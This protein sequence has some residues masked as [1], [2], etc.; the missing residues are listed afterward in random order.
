MVSNGQFLYQS[1]VAKAKLSFKDGSPLYVI[2]QRIDVL[3]CS[4]CLNSAGLNWYGHYFHFPFEQDSLNRPKE[5]A[6]GI[7]IENSQTTTLRRHLQI[8]SKAPSTSTSQT[9]E[10]YELKLCLAFATSNLSFRLIDKPTFRTI[11][12]HNVCH[13]TKFSDKILS[14]LSNIFQN[15]LKYNVSHR[16]IHLAFDLW[17]S[18]N[19][20]HYL[21]LCCYWFSDWQMNRAALDIFPMTEQ[22]GDAIVAAV[23]NVLT[24]YGI[25]EQMIASVCTD[26]ASNEVAAATF[27][28]FSVNAEHV[29]YEFHNIFS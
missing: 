15:A 29:W 23:R 12:S 4:F 28:D 24:K 22:T 18:S 7:K 20:H 16:V 2:I 6:N 10:D 19:H 13:K 5:F 11:L 17:S 26:G 9:V 1:Y 8:H 25:N 14:N 3:Y 21:V 27:P